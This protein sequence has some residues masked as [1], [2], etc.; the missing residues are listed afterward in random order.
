M[1][2]ITNPFIFTSYSEFYEIIGKNK[3]LFLVLMVTTGT[4]VFLT[5]QFENISVT[6][7]FFKGILPGST[8]A[9]AAVWNITRQTKKRHNKISS[10]KL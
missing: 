7:A 4:F 9:A 2:F 6:D 10:E 1:L 8:A 5:T 3:D